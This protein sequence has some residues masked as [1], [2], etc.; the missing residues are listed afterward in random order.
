MGVCGDRCVVH[1][2][3]RTDAHRAAGTLG[4]AAGNFPFITTTAVTSSGPA[5][6][7]LVRL[8]LAESW[9]INV[10]VGDFFGKTTLTTGFD[11]NSVYTVSPQSARKSSLLAGVGGAYTFA[12]HWSVRLDYLRIDRAG[13]SS[14]VG[15]FQMRT[16]LPPE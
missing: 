11:V 14:T 5:L 16:W 10:R 15:K 13:D 4:T 8:P 1:S 12:G 3:R 2:S 7:L 9:D 6:A